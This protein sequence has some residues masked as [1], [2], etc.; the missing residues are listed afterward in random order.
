MPVRP[1]LLLHIGTHKTGTTSQQATLARDRSW[2]AERGVLYP[3][4]APFIG[5]SVDAHHRLAHLLSDPD[6]DQTRLDAFRDDVLARA[7]DAN[8]TLISAEALYRRAYDWA[9]EPQDL[10]DNGFRSARARYLDKVAEYLSDFDVEVLIYFRNVAQFAVSSYKQGQFDN[11]RFT[12]LTDN[13][14]RRPY[15]FTYDLHLEMLE[16]VFSKVRV[17]L[18][19]D[20]AKKGV[21]PAILEELGVT[22]PPPDEPLRLRTSPA[23]AAASWIAMRQKGKALPKPRAHRLL[24]F[25]TSRRG[26]AAFRAHPTTLWDSA[27]D[28]AQ[29]ARTFRSERV[30]ETNADSA[31]VPAIAPWTLKDQA[32]ADRQYWLWRLGL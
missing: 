29:F 7:Q 14:A 1:K 20:A 27:E 21:V 24:E 26:E 19:A 15:R 16:A 30:P 31:H 9:S 12:S 13:I 2:L 8:L 25:A 28:Y 4:S 6:A 18:F 5:G 23:D 10:R 32:K 3:D 22:D 17:R 11:A